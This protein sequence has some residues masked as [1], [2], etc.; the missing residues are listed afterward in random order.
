MADTIEELGQGDH[1]TG[2]AWKDAFGFDEE[3]S[4]CIDFC[5]SA[6][7]HGLQTFFHATMCADATM[8]VVYEGREIIF[9]PAFQHFPVS[10]PTKPVLT[11]C[12]ST[13]LSGGWQR[14]TRRPASASTTGSG[15]HESPSSQTRRSATN[16]R[17][18]LLSIYPCCC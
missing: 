18:L 4:P 5:A 16:V 6:R 9:P 13:S 15:T 11:C 17:H 12:Q 7:T 2:K 8:G 10:I 1:K 14:R 3:D